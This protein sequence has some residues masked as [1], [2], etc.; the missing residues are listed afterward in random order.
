MIGK[1][2]SR[3]QTLVMYDNGKEEKCPICGN[4]VF[5]KDDIYDDNND[6]KLKMINPDQADKLIEK[7]ENNVENSGNLDSLL[8]KWTE[9]TRL[10]H[11]GELDKKCVDLASSKKGDLVKY[12]KLYRA[13]I[14]KNSFY[15]QLI[16]NE[17]IRDIDLDVFSVDENKIDYD[18]HF[19][20][21]FSKEHQFEYRYR[22]SRLRN[23]LNNEFISINFTESEKDNLIPIDY[24]IINME[25]SIENCNDLVCILS[26]EE[27]RKIW[28]NKTDRVGSVYSVLT[29]NM[30][31]KEYLLRTVDEREVKPD[32]I[33]GEGS[34]IKLDEWYVVE[35]FRPV[36][37]IGI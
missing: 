28:P 3:C 34:I 35:Y 33:N 36:I 13:V 14:D 21:S 16:A 5:K 37:R 25:G 9:E 22:Q 27:S 19:S 17:L 4:I 8:R 12:G 2:C 30:I 24:E 15:I 7:L 1:R 23:Y 6:G 11:I 26:G 32:V 31:N 29:N 10:E 18:R 20:V